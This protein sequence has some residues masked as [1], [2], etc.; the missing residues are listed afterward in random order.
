MAGIKLRVSRVF[1]LSSNTMAELTSVIQSDGIR[2]SAIR[3]K[4]RRPVAR[5]ERGLFFP[6]ILINEHV[7][8]S[9]GRD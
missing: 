6:L 5:V 9:N 4:W 7:F 1:L 3:R 8:L 2:A